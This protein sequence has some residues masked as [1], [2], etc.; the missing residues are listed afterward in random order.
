[1]GSAFAFLK[2]NL[3]RDS[4]LRTHQK[5][6]RHTKIFAR[7]WYPRPNNVS[8]VAVARTMCHVGTKSV[9]PSIAPSSEHQWGITLT[10][11]LRPYYLG[12]N[13][14]S[15]SDGRKLSIPSTSRTLDQQTC[16]QVW[17]LLTPVPRRGKF[18]RLASREERGTQDRGPRVYQARQQG[19]VRPMEDSN[20]WGSQ[21]LQ[22]LQ[23]GGACCPQAP[24]ARK[25]SKIVFHLP[26]VYTPR[27]VGSQIFDYDFLTSCMRQL[28]IPKI[29]RRALV[30][31]IPKSEKPLGEPKSCRPISVLCV[32]FENPRE[33]HVRSCRTII[34]PLFPQE[35][36][37]FRIYDVI[38]NKRKFKPPQF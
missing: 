5:S 32:P 36:A 18:H 24:E 17:T 34:N 28:K 6:R 37:G 26:G 27:W 7:A 35:Q 20:T 11:P 15:R 4:H 25:V 21:Y 30:V 14:R 33:T 2:V 13:G 22:T 3:L 23:A 16:W 12:Y 31:A 38:Q 29:W 9:R 1:M 8:Q 10:E 19:T